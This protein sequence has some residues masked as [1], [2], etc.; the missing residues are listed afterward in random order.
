MNPRLSRAPEVSPVIELWD[1]QLNA[2]CRSSGSRTFFG[3]EDETRR[4][5]MRRERDAKLICAGCDVL[6]HCRAWALQFDESHGIWGG[7]TANER[8]RARRKPSVDELE[9]ILD[10]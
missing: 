10:W 8:E 9:K 7:M 6:E 3:S 5:R 4:A 1:W 2:R